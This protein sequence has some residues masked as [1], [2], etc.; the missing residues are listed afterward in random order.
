MALNPDE[1]LNQPSEGPR[2]PGRLLAA[3]EPMGVEAR[4][5]GVELE[6][7]GAALAGPGLGGVQQRLADALRPAIGVDRQVLDPG[8]PAETNRVE[9]EGHSAEAGDGA[10]VVGGEEDLGPVALDDA[11]RGC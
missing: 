4:V 11:V 2:L 6:M 1:T 7:R 5:A 10:V 9:I 3:V 8:A